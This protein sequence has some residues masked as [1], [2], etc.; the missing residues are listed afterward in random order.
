MGKSYV[1]EQSSRGPA[2]LVT[3]E[4]AFGDGRKEPQPPCTQ[5]HR[6]PFILSTPPGAPS[7]G[8]PYKNKR[9]NESSHTLSVTCW[10]LFNVFKHFQ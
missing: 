1:L 10:T 9:R 7:G 6:P 3:G 5:R 2:D 8:T 4:S